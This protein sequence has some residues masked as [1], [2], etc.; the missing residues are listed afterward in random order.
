MFLSYPGK[1]FTPISRYFLGYMGT[2]W[3]SG[4]PG[5][6]VG[7][8]QGL[9]FFRKLYPKWVLRRTLPGYL[10]DKWVVRCH[11]F[12]FW[13]THHRCTRQ[14]CLHQISLFRILPIWNLW[15]VFVF[16]LWSETIHSNRNYRGSRIFLGEFC[17]F[18]IYN[19]R[20]SSL[21]GSIHFFP[22]GAANHQACPFTEQACSK[23][24]SWLGS[25][26]LRICNEF[27]PR[28]WFYLFCILQLIQFIP[29]FDST[30]RK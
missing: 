12:N 24:S 7:K 16:S 4:Q 9:W 10:H 17:C 21:P 23:L 8:R 28:M 15:H 18:D 22:L 27:P 26:P 3:F 13:S 5:A 25:Q 29:Y 19:R 11:C 2:K 20:V 14:V 30:D 6:P 1:L